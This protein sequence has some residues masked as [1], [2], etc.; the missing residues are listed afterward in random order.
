[1]LLAIALALTVSAVPP[2]A[3]DHEWACN[4]FNDI[5]VNVPE[6]RDCVRDT[7]GAT[8]DHMFNENGPL[9]GVDE[10]PFFLADLAME[11]ADWARAQACPPSGEL[12]DCA[13]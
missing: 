10:W 7:P 12:D 2:A 8:Y 13:P 11:N 6:I 1:M 9:H 4:M 3:A 5:D